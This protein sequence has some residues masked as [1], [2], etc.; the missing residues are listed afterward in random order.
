ME[1]AFKLQFIKHPVKIGGDKELVTHFF[2]KSSSIKMITL[3]V[4]ALLIGNNIIASYEVHLSKSPP[5]STNQ[6]NESQADNTQVFELPILTSTSLVIDTDY[7]WNNENVVHRPLNGSLLYTYI[8]MDPNR[9]IPMAGYPAMFNFKNGESK[10]LEKKI[11]SDL[12]PDGKML[13]EKI[14]G[15][16]VFFTEKKKYSYPISDNPILRD[17]SYSFLANGNLL[18]E[19]PS[20][21]NIQNSSTDVVRDLYEFSPYTGKLTF[22][23]KA[24][25]PYS[26]KESKSSQNDY[27]PGIYSPDGKYILYPANFQNPKISVL[28]NISN[29]KIVW[30]GWPDSDMGFYRSQVPYHNVELPVWKRD[31][32]GVIFHR[33]EEKTKIQNLYYLSIDGKETQIT[34]LENKLMTNAYFI[35]ALSLSPNGQY[36]AFAVTQFSKKFPSSSSLLYILDLESYQI[37][38]PCVPLPSEPHFPIWSPDSNTI[39]VF[40]DIGQSIIA[41]DLQE[42]VIFSSLSKTGLDEG[43]LIGW[44]DW[45]I[46]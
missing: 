7:C 36:L 23:K 18:L 38:N 29:Q 42:K 16:W 15:N 26:L 14:S 45:E 5:I 31:S 30:F 4:A 40:P 12:S 27:L 9:I 32:S 22:I 44:I 6:L 21:K 37:L 8:V 46:Q 28:L 13:T 24:S 25:F 2:Y 39:V 20:S 11:P 41:I 43:S 1:F 34:Q 10:G 35:S 33:I 17:S 19:V 3:I